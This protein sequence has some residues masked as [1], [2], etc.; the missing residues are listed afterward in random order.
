MT[1]W[2]WGAAGTDS[3]WYPGS[4]RLFRQGPDGAWEA[5]IADVALALMERTTPQRT[6]SG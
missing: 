4:I 1:D 3:I 5:V 2:R 6:S